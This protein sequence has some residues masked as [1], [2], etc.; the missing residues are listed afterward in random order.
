[1]Y[2]Y[3]IIYSGIRPNRIFIHETIVNQQ[4]NFS[5]MIVL[6]P[7]RNL[8]MFQFFPGN[9]MHFSSIQNVNQEKTLYVLLP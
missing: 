3:N 4:L 5:L 9:Y 1:M 8:Q 6:Q 2:I 7:I